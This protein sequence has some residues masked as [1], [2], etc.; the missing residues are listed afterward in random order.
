MTV[1]FFAG[2][3]SAQ[4]N[5][6][7]GYCG[8][9]LGG[10][11]I[12]QDPNPNEFGAAILLPKEIL[13]KYVGSEINRIDFAIGEKSCE[14]M[15]VFI[16][17]ELG[18][19]ALVTNKVV[20]FDAGWNTVNLK[21]SYTIQKDDELYIGYSFYTTPETTSAGV[22]QFE[23]NKGAYP[24]VNWYSQNNKWWKFD[25]NV[26]DYNLSIR[27]FAEG[28]ELPKTDV[29]TRDMV[30]PKMVIQNKPADYS[31]K[32]RNFGTETVNNLKFNILANGNVFDVKELK[33][34]TLQTTRKSP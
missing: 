17:K 32:I 15:T 20:K 29:G 12:A 1:L 4:N 30:S 25:H 9:E 18:G 13:N 11:V 7:L 33:T 8:D 26:L 21:K 27:A 31:F 19:K 2:G 24:G 10:T 16:T 14:V 6:T 5:V 23:L 22:M 3:L 28:N 34:L